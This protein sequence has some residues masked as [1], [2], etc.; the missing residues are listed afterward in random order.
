MVT[1]RLAAGVL[2]IAVL[3]AAALV[4]YT[5]VAAAQADD[6]TAAEETDG[7]DAMDLVC[8][9]MGLFGVGDENLCD[10]VGAPLVEAATDAVSDTAVGAVTGA[11]GDA[12][13]KIVESAREALSQAFVWAITFWTKLPTNMFGSVELAERVN[14]H[15]DNVMWY[16][17]TASLM[18]AA[19]RLTQA[20]MQGDGS[21]ELFMLHLRVVIANS[22]LAGFIAAAAE[23]GDAFSDWILAESAGPNGPEAVNRLLAVDSF[24]EVAGFFVLLVAI[25]GILGAALQMVFVVMR[26]VILL[27]A[28][29][30]LPIAAAAS[31]MAAG[32][33]SWDRLLKWTI[34]FLLFKPVGA[35]LYALA[36]W[37]G[38]DSQDPM[39][40][41][42]SLI[43]LAM[44]AAVLPM[45]IKLVAPA[46]AAVGA[47]VSGM[48]AAGAISGM[49]VKAGIGAATGGA[50][51]AAGGAAG[52]AAG[53][54]QVAGGAGG[55]M[56]GG[57]GQGFG[58]QGQMAPAHSGG[59]PAAGP[60]GAETASMPSSGP[61]GGGAGAGGAADPAGPSGGP[62]G[63][64]GG[65]GTDGDSGGKSGGDLGPAV[66][67]AGTN[68]QSPLSRLD[69][70]SQM[71]PTM[72]GAEVPR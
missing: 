28:V 38:N 31:G 25:I 52:G 23:A 57:F 30:G 41:F 58:Q 72:G 35:L 5:P 4:S 18:V 14:S 62:S 33:S 63:T 17:L 46:A 24:G 65:G 56:S 47:G 49:A 54:G 29:A 36:F 68:D 37:A 44:V 51:A 45:L 48:A 50:G 61:G 19:I 66:T 27:F 69:D 8:T 64:A 40:V 20:R 12:F 13:G 15:L 10:A 32:T 16:A 9:G 71:N 39:Q 7:G 67:S 21:E 11:A 1:R 26:E 53:A 43:A 6:T 34:A 55:Q 3:F 70:L 2:L 22:M 42:L 59:S 60:S